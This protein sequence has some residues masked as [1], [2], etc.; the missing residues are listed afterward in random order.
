MGTGRIR[1]IPS[2]QLQNALGSEEEQLLSS[3]QAIFVAP[4]RNVA[5]DI[6]FG[7]TIEYFFIILLYW[8]NKYKNGNFEGLED[9]G[10]LEVDAETIEQGDDIYFRSIKFFVNIAYVKNKNEIYPVAYAIILPITWKEFITFFTI[11]KMTNQLREEE[12]IEEETET[13]L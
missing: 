3:I 9:L 13:G 8:V 2:R 12:V 4:I 7:I 11:G 5:I 6:Q 10:E 1:N